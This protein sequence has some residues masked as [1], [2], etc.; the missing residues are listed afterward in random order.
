MLHACSIENHPT[1]HDKTGLFHQHCRY[2]LHKISEVIRVLS[3]TSTVSPVPIKRHAVPNKRRK[4]WKFSRFGFYSLRFFPFKWL[5]RLTDGPI[6]RNLLYMKITIM[7]SRF[8]ARDLSFCKHWLLN[9]SC[10]LVTDPA[11]LVHYI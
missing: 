11:F 10:S 3:W 6:N 7:R 9:S 2:H 1:W 4:P 8:W 5:P